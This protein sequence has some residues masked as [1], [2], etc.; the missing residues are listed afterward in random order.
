[1]TLSVRA[2]LG[3]LGL[4]YRPQSISHNSRA[5]QMPA[6]STEPSNFWHSKNVSDPRRSVGDRSFRSWSA[7]EIL[8]VVRM[9]PRSLHA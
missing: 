5:R 9:K 4:V 7:I 1:M 3:L 8:I 6:G 2:R